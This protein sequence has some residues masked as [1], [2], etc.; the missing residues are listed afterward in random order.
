MANIDDFAID[1]I[2]S[3]GRASIVG[4]NSSFRE[5]ATVFPVNRDI[6]GDQLER[7]GSKFLN[8]QS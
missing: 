2:P 6:L 4:T 3:K 5:R 8:L 7:M 1:L